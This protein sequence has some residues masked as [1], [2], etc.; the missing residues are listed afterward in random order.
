MK[1]GTE[2]EDFTSDTDIFPDS[3]SEEEQEE[4]KYGP[5]FLTVRDYDRKPPVEDE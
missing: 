5:V 4:G 1:S 2:N 3:S